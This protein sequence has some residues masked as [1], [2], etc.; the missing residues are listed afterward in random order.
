MTSL[1]NLGINKTSLSHR[2]VEKSLLLRPKLN[3]RVVPPYYFYT[4]QEEPY[5][6]KS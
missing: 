5:F 6:Y 1:F 3:R 2:R 4:L